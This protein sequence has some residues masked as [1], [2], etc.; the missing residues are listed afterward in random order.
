MSAQDE[1][2]PITQID[3]DEWA[4]IGHEAFGDDRNQWQFVCPMCGHEQSIETAKAACEVDDAEWVP[5][6]CAGRYGDPEGCDWTLGGLFKFHRLEVRR[7]RRMMPVFEFADAAAMEAVRA[8]SQHF[9]PIAYHST[10]IDSWDDWDWEAEGF[11]WV[12]E[13]VRE[14][15]VGFWS[16]C[17]GRSP[18]TWL[19]NARENRSPAMGD[20]VTLS[21]G[22]KTTATG[23]FVHCWNNM[24]RVVTSDGE[25]E[26]VSF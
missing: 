18:R 21:A 10:K 4:K 17:T 19:E 13:K 5:F 26:V 16:C 22:G 3:W 14:Q 7:D 11:A 23:R 15:I 25:Y 6:S 2:R 24:G 20:V 12:P 8:A 9:V 1:V